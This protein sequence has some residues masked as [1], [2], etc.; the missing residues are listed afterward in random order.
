MICHW[1]AEI[2]IENIQAAGTLC[3]NA[4]RVFGTA[5]KTK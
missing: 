2:I 5:F 4:L 1:K 3:K